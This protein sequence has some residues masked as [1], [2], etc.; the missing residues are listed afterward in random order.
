ME[1]QT[2]IDLGKPPFSPIIEEIY[3]N[4]N[5][6]I[7]VTIVFKSGWEFR[8]VMT[9][10]SFMKKNKNVLLCTDSHNNTLFTFT[11][12]SEEDD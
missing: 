4:V 5:E 7:H 11:I 10:E 3:E 12:L 1:K 6:L 8:G 2:T 9:K